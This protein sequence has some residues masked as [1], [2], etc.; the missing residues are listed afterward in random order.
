MQLVAQPSAVTKIETR[1]EAPPQ[2][3]VL[4]TSAWQVGTIHL[5]TPVKGLFLSSAIAS[6]I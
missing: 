4:F 3:V 5:M 2:G 6:L 1:V